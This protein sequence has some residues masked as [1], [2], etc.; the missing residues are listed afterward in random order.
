M[1]YPFKVGDIVYL[2]C[3][4]T[5]E[6]IS[7]LCTDHG[8]GFD[9]NWIVDHIKRY[10]CDLSHLTLEIIE[11]ERARYCGVNDVKVRTEDG[12]TMWVFGEFLSYSSIGQSHDELDK[13]FN[14]FD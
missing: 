12:T 14:E 5:T 13:M 4:L 8:Y 1:K 10:S 3:T 9:H 7:K 6:E 2:N 11:L